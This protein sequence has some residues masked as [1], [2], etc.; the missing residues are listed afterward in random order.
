MID[1]AR[2]SVRDI[3][4]KCREC[5]LKIEEARLKTLADKKQKQ[6]DDIAKKN[7]HSASL[8]NDMLSYGLWQTET[9]VKKNVKSHKNSY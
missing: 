1:N 8:T 9:K 6:I 7:K 3:R 2:K 5:K 4:M